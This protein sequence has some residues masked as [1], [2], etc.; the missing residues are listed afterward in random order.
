M[1]HNDKIIWTRYPWETT[2]RRTTNLQEHEDSQVSPN[3]ESIPI[4]QKEEEQQDDVKL[5]LIQEAKNGITIY[6]GA[7]G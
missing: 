5:T 3:P 4:Q 7:L 6:P 2:P 1:Q